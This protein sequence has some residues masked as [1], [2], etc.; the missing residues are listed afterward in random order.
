M[1]SNRTLRRLLILTVLACA[2]VTSP[3]RADFES[4]VAAYE[5]GAYQEAFREFERL[6]DEGDQRVQGYLE[7]IRKE[8]PA[9]FESAVAAYEGEAHREFEALADEGDQRAE[10]YLDRIRRKLQ[11]VANAGGTSSGNSLVPS[12]ARFDADWGQGPSVDWSVDVTPWNPLEHR[13]APPSGEEIVVPYHASVWST[14]FHLPADATVIVLQHVARVFDARQIYR[15]LQ[16]ISR[17]GN[18]ITLGLLAAFWWFMF[19]RALYGFG[20][21]VGR[22]A[23]AAVSSVGEDTYRG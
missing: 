3:A 10:P 12:D 8:R 4:A 14:L 2:F 9:D 16:V 15:D 7:R 20:Q 5:R 1:S 11:A 17:N 13:P 19:L 18:K 21:F 23:K 22:L 6:A